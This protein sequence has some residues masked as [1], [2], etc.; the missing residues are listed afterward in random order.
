MLNNQIQYE[1][2]NHIKFDILALSFLF[3]LF[4]IYI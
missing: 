1:R 3:V 2:K 4:G